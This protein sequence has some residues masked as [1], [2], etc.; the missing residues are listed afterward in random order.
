M[1]DILLQNKHTGENF[2]DWKRNLLIVLSVEKHKY[3]L[4]KKCPP[5]SNE[6]GRKRWIDSNDVARCYMIG[7]VSSTIQKQIEN[8]KLARDILK[9][10][11]EMFRSQEIMA[12]QSVVSNLMN[13]K[14]KS[15]TS[16]KEHML[17]L[18][19]FLS[20][21]QDNGAEIDYA[22]QV[23]MVFSSLP[24]EYAGFRTAYFFGNKK[25]SLTQLMK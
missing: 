5:K 14:M 4:T 19:G 24:T 23:Q 17:K 2:K 7:S 15:G 13:S 8:I 12:R 1:F 10:L 20:E 3:I 25:L 6:D 21:A 16:V 9:K 11:E 22:T 18:M